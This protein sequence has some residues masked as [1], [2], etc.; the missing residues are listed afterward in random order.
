[1]VGFILKYISQENV[2]YMK[3]ID[4]LLTTTEYGQ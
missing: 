2:W 4:Q 3:Q 1:M